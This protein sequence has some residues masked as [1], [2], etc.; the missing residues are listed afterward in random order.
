MIRDDGCGLSR[1]I[2]ELEAS[3]AKLP[4]LDPADFVQLEEA[5]TERSLVVHEVSSCAAQ[6]ARTKA[7]FDTAQLDS[8]QSAVSAGDE[9]F[10]RLTLVREQ[11]RLDFKDLTRQLE[12]LRSIRG[13]YGLAG[14]TQYSG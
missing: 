8:L 6:M 4:A 2:A 9:A 7:A 12:I 14:T 13:A 5:L 11:I 3:T 10:L 1:A